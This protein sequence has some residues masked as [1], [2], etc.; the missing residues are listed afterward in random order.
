MQNTQVQSPLEV[1]YHLS[2]IKEFKQQTVPKEFY[3]D[4]KNKI[5]YIFPSVSKLLEP[6]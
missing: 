1:R 4:Q 5:K 3:F 6:L 2:K